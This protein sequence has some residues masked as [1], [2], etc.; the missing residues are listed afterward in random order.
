MA[1]ILPVDAQTRVLGLLAEN[2]WQKIQNGL[3]RACRAR[4]LIFVKNRSASRIFRNGLICCWLL[5]VSFIFHHQQCQP[6]EEPGGFF[7]VSLLV[8]TWFSQP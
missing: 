1:S 6:R 2:D 8:F 7:F 5:H 3:L 4:F